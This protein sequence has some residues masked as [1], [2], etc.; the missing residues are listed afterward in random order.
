MM[1]EQQV[2][3]APCRRADAVAAVYRLVEEEWLMTPARPSRDQKNPPMIMSVPAKM[4]A[5]APRVLLADIWLD[6]I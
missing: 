4:A 2:Y 1:A 6:D 5:Q 3:P